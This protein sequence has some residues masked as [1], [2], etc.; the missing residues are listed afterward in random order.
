MVGVSIPL[1]YS[2]SQRPKLAGAESS[3]SSAQFDQD[4][5]R[6]DVIEK[7]DHMKAQIDTSSRK[8]DLLKTKE[9]QLSQAEKALAREYEAGKTDFSSYLKTRRDLLASCY[10]LA[11][12]KARNVGLI[13]EF[14]SYIT[15]DSL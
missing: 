11:A 3:L 2:E 6:R 14:N 9:K 7:L 10:L 1:W 5:A 12:E 15:G 13:A 8:I 4:T